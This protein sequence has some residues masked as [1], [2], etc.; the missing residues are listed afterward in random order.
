MKK[1]T[2]STAAKAS[3]TTAPQS[4]STPSKAKKKVTA[5]K[6]EPVSVKASSAKVPK[7]AIKKIADEKAPVSSSTLPPVVKGENTVPFSTSITALVD[8]GFGN[9]LY[10]RGEGPGLSWE[11]G[12]LLE[13][14]ADDRWT[15]VLPECSQ[16]IVFKVLLNDLTWCA[17]DDYIAQPGTEI[18]VTPTF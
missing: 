8:V 13:C 17:G 5:P 16:P 7:K 18:V 9:S 14:V 1:A 15:L 3:N 10:I 6:A 11:T 4:A 12:V 2:K